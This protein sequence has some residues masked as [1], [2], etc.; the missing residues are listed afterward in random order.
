L[1]PSAGGLSAHGTLDGSEFDAARQYDIADHWFLNKKNKVLR[2]L[3]MLSPTPTVRTET[4]D[5]AVV[6]AIKPMR[7][8]R[9]IEL[10]AE[11]EEPKATPNRFWLWYERP[12]S[13][14]D[15]SAF[16]LEK[17]QLDE[18]LERAAQYASALC[19]ALNLDKCEAAATEVAARLHDLGK[20]RE[21]WQR[22]IGNHKYKLGEILAKSD[23]RMRPLELGRYRHEFGTLIDILHRARPAEFVALDEASQALALHSTAT[24]HGRGRPHFEAGESFDPL[25]ADSRCAEVAGEVLLRFAQLQRK[26]GRWGLA[27]LESLVRAADALA[28]QTEDDA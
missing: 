23:N 20:D 16:A 4:H 25:V 13:A 24:H 19:R 1:P 15:G 14:D 7:R 10:Q 18:H 9:V 22:S 27:W 11:S 3:R 21:L 26:Y 6:E 28:S 8:V 12:R 17:Q 5:A 2:R